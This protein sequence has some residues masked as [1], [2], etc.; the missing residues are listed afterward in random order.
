MLEPINEYGKKMKE[1]MSMRRSER[2]EEVM[3]REIDVAHNY[4]DKKLVY[5]TFSSSL[6]NPIYRKFDENKV[7]VFG[8]NPENAPI[9]LKKLHEYQK[10]VSKD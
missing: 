8:G 3:Q 2:L 10:F 9:V 1:M 6:G 5:I 4:P 7:M